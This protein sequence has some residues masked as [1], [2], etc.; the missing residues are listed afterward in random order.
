MV[1]LRHI[2]LGKCYFKLHSV[3]IFTDTQLELI[4]L[5]WEAYEHFGQLPHMQCDFK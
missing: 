3:F 4:V 1:K 2:Y 5:A